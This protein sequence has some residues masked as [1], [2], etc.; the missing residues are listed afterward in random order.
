MKASMRAGAAPVALASQPRAGHGAF[1]HEQGDP[2]KFANIKN[3]RENLDVCFTRDEDGEAVRRDGTAP[4]A[5]AGARRAWRSSK[6]ATSSPDRPM[7]ST[8]AHPD[9]PAVRLKPRGTCQDLGHAP[10]HPRLS[11]NSYPKGRTNRRVAVKPAG[12]RYRVS[13]VRSEGY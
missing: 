4:K 9:P 2:D 7:D 3:H 5:G 6:L 10:T 11:P 1:G 13:L 12:I 8:L